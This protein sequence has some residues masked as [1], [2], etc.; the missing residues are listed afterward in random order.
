MLRPPCVIFDTIITDFDVNSSQN[1]TLLSQTGTAAAVLICR[2]FEG[3][4]IKQMPV[5]TFFLHKLF[6]LTGSRRKDAGIPPGQIG[7]DT[8]YIW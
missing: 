5:S 1:F 7:F 6:Q 4:L 8:H 3:A 2:C